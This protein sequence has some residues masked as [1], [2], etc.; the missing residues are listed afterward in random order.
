MTPDRGEGRQRT[1]D[2]PRTAV[3]AA[4]AAGLGV[5]VAAAFLHYYPRTKEVGPT[6]AALGD[7]FTWIFGACIGLCIGS[8][9]T[10]LLVRRGSRFAA[11]LVAG[12]AGFWVGVMP[13]LLLTASSDVSQS[14]SFGFAVVV[15]VPAVLFVTAGAAM[16]AS[17]RRLCERR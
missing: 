17:L 2:G 12:F 4:A 9:A 14:D 16:G 10:A 13:Y 7:A 3:G 15:F 11:G 8:S 6:A 5:G 1:V